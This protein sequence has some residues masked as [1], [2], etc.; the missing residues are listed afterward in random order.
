M[1]KI[2]GILLLIFALVPLS[3]C[4]NQPV[5][6][7]SNHIPFIEK[8]LDAPLEINVNNM[9]MGYLPGTPQSFQ[10]TSKVIFYTFFQNKPIKF[11]EDLIKDNESTLISFPFQLSTDELNKF[12]FTDSDYKI[13]KVIL[14]AR[15][16]LHPYTHKLITGYSLFL[17]GSNGDT[18][19]DVESNRLAE[20]KFFNMYTYINGNNEQIK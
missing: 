17:A 4:T 9:Y 3:A 13:G 20:Q 18:W 6:K 14:A 2:P 7:S 19:E 5:N 8:K 16:I 15:S 11:S 1:F 12:G 10:D